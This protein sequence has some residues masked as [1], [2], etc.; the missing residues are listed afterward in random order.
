MTR[1]AEFYEKLEKDGN[2][3]GLPTRFF[4]EAMK[5]WREYREAAESNG[6]K[7]PKSEREWFN[8][9]RKTAENSVKQKKGLLRGEKPKEDQPPP[10]EEQPKTKE[11]TNIQRIGQMFANLIE[12]CR[13]NN[14]TEDEV[15]VMFL[16][17]LEG[18]YIT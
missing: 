15:K 2:F 12:I 8:D 18:L 17:R 11:A 4:K 14:M 1:C 9:K 13:D 10:P 5:Y 6:D 16:D 7:S 3:C